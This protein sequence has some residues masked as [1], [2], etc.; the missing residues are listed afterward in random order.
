MALDSLFPSLSLTYFP[1]TVHMVHVYQGYELPYLQAI[2]YSSL[3]LYTIV[4]VIQNI[5]C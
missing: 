5:K 4:K 2:S 1:N 3:L